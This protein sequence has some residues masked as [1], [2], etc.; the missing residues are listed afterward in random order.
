MPAAGT[1][2]CRLVAGTGGGQEQTWVW[3]AG[4]EE[5]GQGNAGFGW[6][7]TQRRGCVL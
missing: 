6:V 2:S 3:I 1:G 5:C 4:G 7:E